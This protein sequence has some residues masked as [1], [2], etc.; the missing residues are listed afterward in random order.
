ML[1]AYVGR[2]LQDARTVNLINEDDYP[3]FVR[4]ELGYE[5]KDILYNLVVDIILN[6]YQ[7]GSIQF[8]DNKYK[9]LNMLK[10]FNNARIYKH[11]KI[12][13]EEHKIKNIFKTLYDN[14]LNDYKTNN[15]NSLFIKWYSE[16]I[17]DEIKLKYQIERFIIDF[18]AGMTDRYMI[19]QFNSIVQLTNFGEKLPE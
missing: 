17:T 11:P 18:I 15:S 6:S 5:N 1:S 3:D 13:D 19:K 4:T 14:Y 10:D 2:D 12:V 7:K 16:D 9:A 8:S